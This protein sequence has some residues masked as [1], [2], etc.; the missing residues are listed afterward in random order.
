MV[1]DEGTL[2]VLDYFGH[3]TLQQP[4]IGLLHHHLFQPPGLFPEHGILNKHLQGEI[5]VKFLLRLESNL[6]RRQGMA[7]QAE[8]IVVTADPAESQAFGPGVGQKPL[9]FTAGIF[10]DV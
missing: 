8:E 3:Q 10:A 9:K 7:A 5:H 4:R 6:Q 1:A 2:P